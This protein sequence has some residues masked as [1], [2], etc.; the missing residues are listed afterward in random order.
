MIKIAPSILSADFSRLFAEVQEIEKGEADLIHFDV[1]DGAFVNNITFGPPIIK[2]LRPLTKLPFDVHLMI[3][4]PDPFLKDFKDAG[5]D[6]L[7]VHAE[8]CVHLHRTLRGIKDHGMKAG[9]ALNP[10]TPPVVLEEVLDEVDLI[11]VM[12]VNPGLGG[13]KFIRSA[14]AKIEKISAMIGK[15]SSTLISV[16]GGINAETAPTVVEAGAS[17]LVAGSFI[18]S[19][20]DYGG[21]IKT[22]KG[23]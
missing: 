19:A 1:M 22:L 6:Y 21:A 16:D 14:L 7:T 5:S 11:L 4:N 2:S 15:D 12:S 3:S 23:I 20:S 8:T 10:A 9:V 17:V 18:F 13:Q